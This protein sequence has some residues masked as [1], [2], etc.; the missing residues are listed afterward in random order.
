MDE[1]STVAVTSLTKTDTGERPYQCCLCRET[2]CRSDILKRHFNKCSIRRGN[3]TGATHLT[4]AQD[5]IRSGQRTPTGSNADANAQ[6]SHSGP[7]NI[8]ISNPPSSYPGNWQSN[9]RA[10]GNFH[11]GTEL[12]SPQTIGD[13]TRSSRSSSIGRPGSSSD[14]DIKK[15]FS[16]SSTVATSGANVEASPHILQGSERAIGYQYGHERQV[17]QQVQQQHSQHTRNL[18][19]GNFYPPNAESGLQMG[20]QPEQGSSAGYYRPTPQQYAAMPQYD[21]VQLQQQWGDCFSTGVQDHL[22]YSGQ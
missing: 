22:M 10:F 11:N 1:P 16:S 9:P 14:D 7:P 6:A 21:A 19:N 12:A 17:M 18:S 5:H 13:S 20:S 2:F 15:R 4:H 3:P 8:A